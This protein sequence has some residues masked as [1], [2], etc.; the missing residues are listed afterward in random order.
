MASNVARTPFGQ[1]AKATLHLARLAMALAWRVSP[2]LVG[3]TIGVLA[4][5]ALVSPLQPALSRLVLDRAALDLGHASADAVAAR[6]TLPLWIMLMAAALA[7]GQLL[8]PLAANFQSA[9]GDRLA[10]ALTAR[11]LEAVSRWQGL[12]RFEDATFQDDL[13]RA[14][15]RGAQGGLELLT[16]G[17]RA[18]LSLFTIAGLAAVLFRFQ[19][20]VVA[21]LLLAT[22]PQMARRWEFGHRTRSYL[23]GQTPDSRQLAYLRDVTLLP[24]AAKDVRL[25]D[26]GPFFLE[27]YTAVFQR[28]ME[29]LDRLRQRLMGEVALAS[30]LAA[31]AAGAV[32][33][34]VLYVVW[35][36]QQGSASVGDLALYGGAATAM[37]AS[38][39]ML[40][41]D[42][43]F[44]PQVLG[45]LP[46]LFR[47]LHAPPDLPLPAQRPFRQGIVFEGVGFRYP[48]AT[49]PV[50]R[51]LSL[52][53]APGESLALVGHNGAGKTTLVKLLLRLYDPTEGRILLDGVNL[54]EYDL[55]DLR[56]E[57]GV[58]FQDFVRYELTVRENVAMGQ[59]A[60]LHDE[61]RLLGALQQ[62][63]AL[64]L[65]AAMPQGLDTLLGR[66]FGGRELSGGE[67]QKLALARPFVRDAQLLV[68]DEPT[69]ALDVPTEHDIY[70]RFHELTR[71]RLTVLISHRFSTVRMA[72]RILYLAAGQIQE[73]GSHAELLAAGGAG[74]GGAVEGQIAAAAGW[75]GADTLAA[76]LPCSY[77]TPLTRRF[78]G[79]TDL[80]GG[81]WQKVAL[82]RAVVRDAALVI[83]DEPTD[84][85]D[86]DAEYALFARFRE[87]V[88]GKTAL[89]RCAGA[90]PHAR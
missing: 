4:L 30:A 87:L 61:Q 29:R 6:A 31:A 67:W 55:D 70:R 90:R 71:G 23:Y 89:P 57:V 28:T 69:A 45:F 19:P 21:L 33:L 40:G 58:V 86:A 7:F 5:Q 72:D 36:V 64:P 52:H 68:L 35:R 26:L 80:S 24:E 65:L 9:A 37:Q 41:F 38:V 74:P 15:Q 75:S 42:L 20:V 2:L 13:E 77:A 12:A 59:L 48:G 34:Y 83:L 56:R 51:G 81:E 11:L 43:A 76:K 3:A 49:D 27:R 54:R 78:A 16:Y 62:A 53:L 73:E 22:I 63:G 82:A 60:A 85:L 10:A 14:R 47:L 25:Y 44:L 84:A 66:E 18:L 1:Q 17:T 8:Q 50:L 79:G 88:R 39:L 46:S 32:Y